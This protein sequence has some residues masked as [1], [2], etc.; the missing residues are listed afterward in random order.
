MTTVQ[1]ALAEPAPAPA[2]RA[3]V[4][5]FVLDPAPASPDEARR[6]FAARL[7]FETDPADLAIDLERRAANLV[8][9]DSRS[10]Q[11]Y[12]ACHIPGAIN[13]PTRTITADSTA[14]LPKDAV[15]VVYC[16][17][18]GCNGSTRASLRLATLG[19]QVKELIGG[20]E[21][22]RLEG[23]AVEGTLGESAPMY[24]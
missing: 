16:W 17:S 2:A 21:Y 6:H 13:L 12:E 20:L 18:P 15:L 10:P 4:H 3:A 23:R 14:H 19:F 22:W 11:A 9:V 24:G 7:A 8:V 1:S 5:S